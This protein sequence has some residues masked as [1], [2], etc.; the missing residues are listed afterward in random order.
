MIV[1]LPARFVV[2]WVC[3]EARFIVRFAIRRH[4]GLLVN[5][6]HKVPSLVEATECNPHVATVEVD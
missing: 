2:A 1:Q 6:A 4:V 5:F 3:Q